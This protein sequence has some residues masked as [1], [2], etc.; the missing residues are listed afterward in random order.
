MTLEQ[1]TVHG[2]KVNSAPEPPI[3]STTQWNPL[4]RPDQEKV[5]TILG[6]D[7]LKEVDHK[8]LVLTDKMCVVPPGYLIRNKQ[9]GWPRAN[10]SSVE[11]LDTSAVIAPQNGL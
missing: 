6:E 4:G 10:A 3:S 2:P 7:Q 5:P 11:K 8:H 9:N 1:M